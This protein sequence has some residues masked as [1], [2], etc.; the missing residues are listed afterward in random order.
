MLSSSL[1]VDQE[2]FVKAKHF[3]TI[4]LFHKLFN[5]YEG[6]FKVITQSDS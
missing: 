5:Q 4:C 1:E 6:P 2:V 3:C